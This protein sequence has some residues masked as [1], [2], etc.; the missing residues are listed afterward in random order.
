MISKITE[1]F[2]D[3]TFAVCPTPFQQIYNILGDIGSTFEETKVVPL[4]SAFMTNRT[5]KSYELLFHMIQSQLPEFKPHK[6]HCDYESAAINAIKEEYPNVIIKGCYYHWCK[7]ISKNA[8][9]F[10]NNETKPEKRIV[11]LTAAL[12]LLPT[13]CTSEGWE[14]I[15][16]QIYR[17]NNINMTRFIRYIE[18]YWL[19]IHSPDLFSVYGERH[20]TDNVSEGFHSKLIKG[21]NKTTV[22]LT[23]TMNKMNKYLG[24]EALEQKRKSKYNVDDDFILDVQMQLINGDIT[25]AKALDEL[26]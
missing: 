7:R 4:I 9:K 8:K 14:Y 16:T 25:V 23:R 21:I 26:R 6:V 1:Y 24:M 11:S 20:R 3:G 19:K 12:P 13:Q 22:T 18:N 2:V 5:Q 15:K 10:K 17:I